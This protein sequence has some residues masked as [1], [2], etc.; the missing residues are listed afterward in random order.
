MA[1]G[2]PLAELVL[3]ADEA[4][5]LATMVR[6]PKSDQRTALRA[7]IV[8]DCASGMSNTAVAE[9]HEVTLATV[10][11]W[12]HRFVTQRLAGLGDAPRPGQPRKITDAKIDA[13]VT[14]TL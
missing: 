1:L 12:R 14:R 11:K 5:K 3:S 8:L 2:R 4:A 6:R 13:V 7:G 10:G 9:R